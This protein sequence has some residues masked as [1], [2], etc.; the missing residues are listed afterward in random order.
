MTW[1]PFAGG[2]TV[3]LWCC[4]KTASVDIEAAKTTGSNFFVF[5]LF[6]LVGSISGFQHAAVLHEGSPHNLP[7]NKKKKQES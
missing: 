5:F 6:F 3:S 7:T 2:P 1:W 4:D